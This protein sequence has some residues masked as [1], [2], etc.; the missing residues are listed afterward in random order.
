MRHYY[1]EILKTFFHAR[2]MK[3]KASLNWSQAKLAKILCMDSRSIVY[4]AHGDFCCSALSL[5]MF[6]IYCC[7]NPLAFLDDLRKEFEGMADNHITTDYS[8][9]NHALSYRMSLQVFETAE[10]PNGSPLPICPRCGTL[11]HQKDSPYCLYCGQMLAW[12]NYSDII[13]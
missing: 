1:E 10:D 13:R 2:L 3:A 11:I 4:L 6:L 8:A 12:S 7:E 9:A 5:A